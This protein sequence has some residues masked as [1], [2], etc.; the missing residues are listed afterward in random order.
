MSGWAPAPPSN[1]GEAQWN[2]GPTDDT[3][4]DNTGVNGG[5]ATTSFDEDGANGFDAR[6]GG[7]NGAC[8]NCG[9]EGYVNYRY[10]K[11]C[12]HA[13]FFFQ[14]QQGRLPK[15]SRPEMSTLQ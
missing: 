1:A 6:G 10:S 4:N 5:G 7:G 13:N 15:P 8:F 2:A 3:W 12:C 11:E 9:Q 14:S